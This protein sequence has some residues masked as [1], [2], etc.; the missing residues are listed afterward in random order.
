MELIGKINREEV[1]DELAD[2]RAVGGYRRVEADAILRQDLVA[3]EVVHRRGL[4]QAVIGRARNL[5]AGGVMRGCR[6]ALAADFPG[7][8][9]EQDR[10]QLEDALPP[11]LVVDDQIGEKGIAVDLVALE[12]V[13][14]GVELGAGRRDEDAGQ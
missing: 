13:E 3:L 7:R 8:G 2:G 5:H 1:L 10:L 9:A 6:L 4:V 12:V 14:S 11:E